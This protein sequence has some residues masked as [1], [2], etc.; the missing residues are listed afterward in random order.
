M[1]KSGGL[2]GDA[3]PRE[4]DLAFNKFKDEVDRLANRIF[5]RDESGNLPVDSKFINRMWF[6]PDH[7]VPVPYEHECATPAAYDARLQA[8]LTNMLTAG[9]RLRIELDRRK[10][11]SGT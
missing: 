11:E 1:A 10:R 6:E 2:G 4:F 3:D 7:F 5:A 9:K 8:L